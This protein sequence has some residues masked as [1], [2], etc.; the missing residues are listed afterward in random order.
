M[1][2]TSFR[3]NHLYTQ[4]LQLAGFRKFYFS[5]SS[6]VQGTVEGAPAL[7]LWKILKLLLVVLD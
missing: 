5:G 1:N 7:P 3:A 4:K 6:G 2:W